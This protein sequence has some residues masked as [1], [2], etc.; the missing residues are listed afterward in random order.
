[1]LIYNSVRFYN[2]SLLSIE[3]LC[4]S[5]MK[6]AFEY[7]MRFSFALIKWRYNGRDVN[8]YLLLVKNIGE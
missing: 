8:I 1:M 4:Q 5:I 3:P 6:G 7:Y 2:I